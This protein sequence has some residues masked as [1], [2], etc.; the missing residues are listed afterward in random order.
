MFLFPS[1][2][3]LLEIQLDTEF[4][5]L[6]VILVNVNFLL[7]VLFNKEPIAILWPKR[8]LAYFAGIII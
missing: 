5:V 1:L 7:I 4:Y 2:R 8:L 6:V 3:H